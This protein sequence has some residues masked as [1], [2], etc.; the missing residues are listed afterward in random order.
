VRERRFE[1]L[2]GTAKLRSRWAAAVLCRG[3]CVRCC[4]YRVDGFFSAA[5]A[6][7]RRKVAS[8]CDASERLLSHVAS[9]G[10]SASAWRLAL[11]PRSSSESTKDVLRFLG[12]CLDSCLSLPSFVWA[13]RAA[14]FGS[15]PLAAH[16]SCEAYDRTSHFEP[17]IPPRRLFAA[18]TCTVFRVLRLLRTPA[19]RRLRARVLRRRE[20]GA[21][22]APA[23][24]AWAWRV[25]PSTVDAVTA[26]WAAYWKLANGG[27]PR[28]CSGTDGPWY[29]R[30]GA[31]GCSN[32]RQASWRLDGAAWVAAAVVW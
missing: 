14:P 4:A 2:A 8:P 3:N 27:E 21:Y 29:G 11:L 32:C 25:R 20:L 31:G 19:P 10:R 13:R 30:W 18:M 26:A 15:L 16:P 1:A 24:A 17:S 22:T 7:R 6:S 23:S 12:C 9:G 5:T 28:E